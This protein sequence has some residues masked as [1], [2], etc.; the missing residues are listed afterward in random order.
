MDSLQTTFEYVSHEGAKTQSNFLGGFSLRLSA[1]VA[2]KI[3][4][5]Q[6]VRLVAAIEL[7][8]IK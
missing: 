1:F 2:I 8:T 3:L 5:F 6:L 4:D 7:P